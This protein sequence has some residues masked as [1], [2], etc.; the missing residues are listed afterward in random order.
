MKFQI[1]HVDGHLLTIA[2]DVLKC[3]ASA[4]FY[5]FS[6]MNAASLMKVPMREVRSIVAP[7]PPPGDLAQ[8]GLESKGTM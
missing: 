2:A 1:E 7:A 6:L 5:E 4:G 3:D 8:R